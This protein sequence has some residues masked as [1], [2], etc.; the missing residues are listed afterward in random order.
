MLLWGDSG[1]NLCLLIFVTGCQVT[2][3]SV[4]RLPEWGPHPLRASYIE[5]VLRLGFPLEAT[6]KPDGG[7]HSLFEVQ[8]GTR[9]TIEGFRV[10]FETVEAG[11]FLRF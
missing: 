10:E 9:F 3:A 5:N 2:S 6:P 4:S 8:V 11:I 7:Y 1:V